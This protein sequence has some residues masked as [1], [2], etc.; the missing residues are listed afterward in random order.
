MAQPDSWLLGGNANTHP[1][2]HF[3]GTTDNVPL[4]FGVNNE[5]AG[6]LDPSNENI[7]WGYRSGIQTLPDPDPAKLGGKRNT[8]LGHEALNSNLSGY[9]NIAIGRQALFSNISGFR[10]TAVGNIA[11][12]NTTTGF[13]NTAVGTEALYNNAG[14]GENTAVGYGSLLTNQSGSFNTLLGSYADVTVDGLTNATAIGSRALVSK[15]DNLVLGGTGSHAVSVAIGATEADPSAVLD[16]TSSNKGLLI[17]R[18]NT[19]QRNGLIQTDGLLTYDTDTKSFW[20]SDGA[21]WKELTTAGLYWNI[22]GNQAAATDAIGT[23]NDIA[24]QLK[25]F[26]QQAGMIQ[27]TTDPS[28]GS[29]A[30]GFR[31]LIDGPGTWNTA[32]G[33]ENQTTGVATANNTSV[34]TFALYRNMGSTNTAIGSTSLTSNETGSGNVA[35][36]YNTFNS[37]VSGS[38]NTI[39]GSGADANADNLVYATAIGAESRV[40]KSNTIVLGAS[41]VNAVNVAIGATE[42]HSS[43]VLDIVSDNKGVLIPRIDRTQ[44][45]TPAEGLLVYDINDKGF[46]YFDGA[47]WK[48][49]T[50]R[51][52]WALDGND[53]PTGS[54]IGTRNNEPLRFQS[55]NMPAGS[56]D[57]IKNNSFWGTLSGNLL[58][59]AINN[60]ATGSHALGSIVSGNNNTA[61]GNYALYSTIAGNN[62]TALGNRAL[63][64]NLS[65]NDNTASG[66][67]AMISNSTGSRNAAFGYQAL[68]NTTSGNSNTGFGE[69]SL[70]T[71][72]TGTGNTA[73]GSGADVATAALS[74]ATAIGAGAVVDADNKIRL[75]NTVLTAVESYGSFYTRGQ[76]YAWNGSAYVPVI[77][78]WSLGGNA[79]TTAA[80][81]IGNTDDQP[82]RFRINGNAAG[83][84]SN[85]AGNNTSL[86]Y[87]ALNNGS[88]SGNTVIGALGMKTNISGT[89]NT[90]IGYNADVTA[91]NLINATAIG[92]G[93]SIGG[94]NQMAF[95]NANVTAWLFGK[96]SPSAAGRALE[97]GFSSSNGNGAFLSTAGVWTNVSDINK[98]DRF[99][100]VDGEALLEQLQQ[101]DIQQWYYKETDEKH[102]GPYAQQFYHLFGLGNGDDKSISTIDP[103]GIALRAIQEQQKKLKQQQATIDDLKTKNASLEQ[104]V[105]QLQEQVERLA[106]QAGLN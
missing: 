59:T 96:S 38:S 67:L 3:I 66:N 84:I 81:F 9:G 6:L 103:S 14:G 40:S 77:N 23:N 82:L 70:L 42:A 56:V 5:S 91:G 88:G 16:I 43:A 55:G 58:T 35:I 13:R 83:F 76:Y 41:G 73:I 105:Q 1:A 28:N 24:L 2:T 78:G 8:S 79:N 22:A 75:G 50:D 60:T 63:Y 101:L 93:A 30:Y 10:N 25:V 92:F 98:K 94:N 31:S 11:L 26:G 15:S 53:A 49:T 97:V 71:N 99:S 39:I 48:S 20:Y 104:A 100:A 106:R 72:I 36:G 47:A 80:N 37:N 85:S 34:G 61:A 18:L 46:Y 17:P 4:R 54:F 27:S 51:V 52:G 44:V 32:V 68:Y 29:T 45:V 87:R 57:P 21:A 69:G 89:N 12:F 86:G 64:S 62:N 65:G 7:F 90:I 19:L 95:G 102:I 33:A 74:N